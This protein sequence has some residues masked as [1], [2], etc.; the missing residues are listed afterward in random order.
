[1]N[2]F[3]EVMN[4]DFS[5]FENRNI[6]S[7][8]YTPEEILCR[9]DELRNIFTNIKP[10][11]LNNKVM[12]TIL[13]GASSSGKTTVMK[14][15]LSEI[16]EISGITTCYINCNIQNTYRKCY[17]QLYRVLFG[18]EARRNVGTE[19]IQ[20]ELM[21]KLEEESVL[22][23]IDDLDHLSRSDADRFINEIFRANE[24]Y[25]TN[26]ALMV[27]IHSIRFKYSLDLDTQN[28][29]LGQIIELEPYSEVEIE[30]ILRYR[31][32]LG[33]KEG[34]I[35][36]EDIRR[37]SRNIFYYFNLRDGLNKLNILG[38]KLDFE[39]RNCVDKGDLDDLLIV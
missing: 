18:F 7:T 23:A 39:N 3:D 19:I 38:Q 20:D 16:E 4:N 27:S 32:K 21:K 14:F 15:V 12:N 37:V 8:D 13:I 33:F 35:S 17:L 6:F 36:D 28:I 2:I 1:M 31:C 30:T 22:L 5:V 26:I 11:L 29:F 10:L 25:H 34:V 24:F 9:D